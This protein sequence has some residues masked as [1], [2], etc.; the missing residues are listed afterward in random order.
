MKPTI[1]ILSICLTFTLFSCESPAENTPVHGS[2]GTYILNSGNWG[3]NDANICIY[4]PTEKTFAADAFYAANGQK[5]GDV[6]QDILV[7]DDLVYVAVNTSQT[8]FVTD[9][10]LKIKK[11]LDAEADGARL[12]PRVFAAHGNKVYVT[13]Y[14][15]YLGEISKD[16][17]LRLCAVGPNPDGVAIAGD[18]L[19]VA[20]SGGM[21]YPTYNNTVSVVSTDSFTEASTIEVNVNPAMVAASSDGKYVYVSSFGNY[22]DQPA[23]LQ[24]ITTSNAGVTDLEYQSVSA[25]AKG[26]NDVLYILCGGYDENWNPLPGTIYKHDMKTNSP[27]GSFVTDGTTLPN[28]YSI[29]VAADGYIYVGCSDYKTTGDVYV[30]SKEGKLHDKFDSQGLNPIKAF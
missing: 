21:S 26:R 1:L 19:Y 3:D 20:N 16:Y 4:N 11:Q 29:S 28:A 30:F 12:S 5:L 9:S 6:G 23:K 8:I 7:Y 14:E 24:V 25:I 27:L 15:G 22:A 10:D 17:S 13:Y 2:S 18:N